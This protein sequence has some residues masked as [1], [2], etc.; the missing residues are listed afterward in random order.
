MNPWPV[1]VVVA[2]FVIGLTVYVAA[3]WLVFGRLP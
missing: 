1:L 3:V 2:G